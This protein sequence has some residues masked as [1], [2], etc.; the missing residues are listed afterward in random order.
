MSVIIDIGSI[1]DGDH[2]FCLRRRHHITFHLWRWW[3]W[4]LILGFVGLTINCSRGYTFSI[5]DG[6]DVEYLGDQNTPLNFHI[7]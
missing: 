5:I 3:W 4:W 6:K 7:I 2:S 1:D